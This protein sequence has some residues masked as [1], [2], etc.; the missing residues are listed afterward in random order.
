MIF[1]ALPAGFG[2]PIVIVQHISPRSDSQWISI[3]DKDCRIKL[4]EADEKEKLQE[5]HVYLAPP[6]YHLL[7]EADHSFS[8]TVDER[9]NYARP[10]ID[11]LF[12]TAACAYKDNLIGVVLTGANHDGA[13]GLKAIRECGGLCIVQ[14]PTTAV[15]RYMPEAALAAVKPDYVLPLKDI[16]ELLVSLDTVT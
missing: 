13:A 3:L 16:I 10:A 4:K 14:D 7:I 11:V 9:V 6:N 15:S 2:I 5:G 1:S 12:E 8:L